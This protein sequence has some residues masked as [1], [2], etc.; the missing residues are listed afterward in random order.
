MT[1][2]LFLLIAGILALHLAI[3][4]N[5]SLLR[6]RVAIAIACLAALPL[7]FGPVVPIAHFI[8]EATS[9]PL[10]WGVYTFAAL[11]LGALASR[12]ATQWKNGTHSHLQVPFAG[13]VLSQT[14]LLGSAIWLS[15][16]EQ[17]QPT[18]ELRDAP[19]YVGNWLAATAACV[20]LAFA[21]WRIPGSSLVFKLLVGGYL[22][23]VAT[24]TYATL[25][26]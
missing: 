24:L 23:L 16:Y 9:R 10:L 1:F 22:V 21:A 15:D 6:R 8:F 5:A 2:A 18:P 26:P 14:I 19:I 11:I 12:L 17:G 20:L 7:T 25:S 13:V 3:A 4:T